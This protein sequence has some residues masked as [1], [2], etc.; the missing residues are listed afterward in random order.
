MLRLLEM[1]LD[2]LT[3]QAAR[4]GTPTTIGMMALS[5]KTNRIL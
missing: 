3:C 4:A 5:I 2:L 1:T